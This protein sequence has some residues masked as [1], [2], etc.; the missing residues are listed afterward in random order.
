MSHKLLILWRHLDIFENLTNSRKK[1]KKNVKRKSR[2]QKYLFKKFFCAK[3]LFYMKKI[4]ILVLND[5]LSAFHVIFLTGR[6]KLA[7]H[8]YQA[9][10][11]I[12]GLFVYMIVILVLKLNYSYSNSLR[13]IIESKSVFS[14][15]NKIIDVFVDIFN[16]MSNIK[17]N[18]K[19]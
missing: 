4:S 12:C 17:K 3:F 5:I 1:M 6:P 2:P 15:S 16:H 14:I 13:L 8:I 7:F 10:E 9:S 18:D 19:R 11:W